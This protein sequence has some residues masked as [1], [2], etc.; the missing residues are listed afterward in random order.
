[1][2]A[3]DQADTIGYVGVGQMGGAIVARLATQHRVLVHDLSAD[4]VAAAVAQGA[5]AADL[6]RIGS[7]CRVIF[8]C[9]PSIEQV[10]NALT[11]DAPLLSGIA[12]GTLI[13]DQTTSH[14]LRFRRLAQR[15]TAQGVSLIDAPVSGGPKGA[16][17][18]TL[19]VTAGGT[20]AEF[21]RLSGLLTPVTRH[22]LHTGAVGTAMLTKVTN[23]Y[24]AAVQ[25]AV[26]LEVLALAA[27][28]D[29]DPIVTVQA[30]Q[31][32]SGS[33][34]FVRRFLADHVLTGELES[35]AA[36]SVM[37]KDV[38]LALDVAAAA[39]HKLLGDTELP[40][41]I[42]QCVADYGSA[43]PYCALARSVSD[44]TGSALG[45]TIGH[46]LGYDRGLG[47]K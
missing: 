42:D 15:L 11:P 1:M 23:N 31:Q 9:L 3:D 10:E 37:Q 4:A 22:V 18:G 32:G 27:H 40:R 17:D 24:M 30:M 16:Q 29:C 33:N 39:G 20:E 43:A 41:L 19:L 12:S 46:R 5:Q 25:A 28:F 7:E 21:S 36:I 2:T 13:V 44:E 47:E 8:L 34:Y 35:G 14:P 6:E 45:S 26:S 38:G